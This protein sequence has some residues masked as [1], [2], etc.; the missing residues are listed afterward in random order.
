[1]HHKGERI[2]INL[3]SN[4]DIGE[5]EGCKKPILTVV[6]DRNMTFCCPFCLHSVILDNKGDFVEFNYEKVALHEADCL[7]AGVK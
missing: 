6:L 5:C 2:S 7:Q 4:V 3:V 1:M